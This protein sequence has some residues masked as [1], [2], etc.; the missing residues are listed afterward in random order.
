MADKPRFGGEK[1]KLGELISK[2]KVARCGSADYPVLSMTMHDGIVEQSGRFKKAI[3]SK[4]KSTYKVVNPGQLVVGFPKDEG[5]L[6]IQN[7]GYPGI[8]SPAYNVWNIDADKVLPAYLELALHSPQSMNYYASKLMGTTARRRSMP[9]ETLCELPIPLPGQEQQRNIVATLAHLKSQQDN[10][11]HQLAL[12]DTLVK[13]R[14]VEMFGDPIEHPKWELSLLKD[15]CSKLGS[16]ATPRGGKS[17]YKASGI[18]LIR[19]MNVHNGAFISK[20]LAHIDDEQAEKLKG[21]TLEKGDVLLNIT[22]ASV[23]RSCVLPDELAGGR[24]NQH[25]AIVRAD[26]NRILPCVLNATFINAS[27][28]RFLLNGSRM[29]GATREAITKEDLKNMSVPIPPLSLQQEFADFVAQ[30]DKSRF[31][32]QQQ[33]DKLQTLYDSLAQEYFA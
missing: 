21:V 1:V 14:F 19:S 2:A 10:A 28:Q 6:Y 13:S 22:G 31:V 20:E 11:K 30:V 33:I 24:V 3:A 18:P 7:C 27:F 23:A 4:D 5:V 25:V 17:A 12:L 9:A 32:V 26:S 8:M 29:A 16:G 15:I